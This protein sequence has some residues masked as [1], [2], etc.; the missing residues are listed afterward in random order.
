MYVVVI[1]RN[2][3]LVFVNLPVTY[4]SPLCLFSSVFFLFNK[5]TYV[6]EI[7]RRVSQKLPR[8]L[9]FL[10]GRVCCG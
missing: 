2:C 5:Q 7:G 4:F 9:I 6:R 3:E 10:K 1:F 8:L